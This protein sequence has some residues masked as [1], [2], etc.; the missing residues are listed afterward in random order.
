MFFEP[1][2]R[3]SGLAQ[4][5]GPALLTNQ[6]LRLG[7]KRYLPLDTQDLRA[8]GELAKQTSMCGDATYTASWFN[9]KVAASDLSYMDLIMYA[10]YTRRTS[11]L[12]E[13]MVI[14]SEVLCA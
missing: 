1:C 8:S 14:D 3:T 5:T 13:C 7:P 4:P 12:K 2:S 9:G 10:G 11:M 6:R